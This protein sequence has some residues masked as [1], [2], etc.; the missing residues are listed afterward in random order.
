MTNKNNIL[1]DFQ[2][3]SQKPPFKVP[4]NYFETLEER[5]ETRI[6]SEAEEVSKKGKVIRMLKPILAMAAS[7]ALVFLLV[8]YPLSVFLPDYMA[9][10]SEIKVDQQDSVSDDDILFSYFPISDEALYQA[11]NNDTTSQADTSIN[12]D[13]MLDYLSTAMN[14]TEIYAE[15][16][17]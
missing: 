13:E 1:P 17:N 3:N 15:F 9:K 14:E 5:I 6:A 7:F 16:Q 8:Y 12:A 11:L 10:Q 4:E 2:K